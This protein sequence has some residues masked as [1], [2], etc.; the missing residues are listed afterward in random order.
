MAAHKEIEREKIKKE[1]AKNVEDRV[2]PRIQAACLAA[3][4]V[5]LHDKF[6]FGEKRLNKYIEEVFEVFESIY[7]GYVSFD[8][9]KACIYDELGIDF[10]ALEEKKIRER[11]EREAV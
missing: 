8:D 10:D 7:T 3:T 11:M 9:L 4:A 6:G 5:V 2:I 1:I